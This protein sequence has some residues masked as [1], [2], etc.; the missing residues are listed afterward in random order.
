M[1]KRNS[2]EN[3]KNANVTLDKENITNKDLSQNTNKIYLKLDSLRS[4]L[5]LSSSNSSLYLLIFLEGNLAFVN[6]LSI[7][8]YFIM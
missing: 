6:L 1:I 8:N 2:G 7:D 4:I 5:I 3:T